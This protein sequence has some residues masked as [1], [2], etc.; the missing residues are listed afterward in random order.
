VSLSGHETI[1]K[2][3]LALIDNASQFIQFIIT[4][5]L[6]E[7]RDAFKIISDHLVKAKKNHPSIKIE[8]ALN[9][10]VESYQFML[11]K[12]HEYEILIYKWDIGNVLPF[13]LYLSENSYIFTTLSIGATPEYNI[14]LTI[15]N[16][17]PEMMSGFKHLFE[18]N[19]ISY[20]KK[21][22]MV[23]LKKVP[24]NSETESLKDE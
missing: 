5:D 10:D 4:P 13:G 22:K 19:Y 18:W 23:K 16:A 17:V 11:K 9:L 8:I 12:L 15:E 6:S 20:Y 2:S 3:I 1:F 21:G 24:S 14:G 7:N